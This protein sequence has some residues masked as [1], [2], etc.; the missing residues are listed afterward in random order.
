MD[1]GRHLA[2]L[3]SGRP[4]RLMTRSDTSIFQSARL[5]ATFTGD[6]VPATGFSGTVWFAWKQQQEG[7]SGIIN[8]CITAYGI[9]IRL[10]PPFWPIFIPE[11]AQNA[12]SCR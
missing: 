12:P 5:P 2:P 11:L 4:C 8:C 9:T 6:A 10:P 7:V 3:M 1:H